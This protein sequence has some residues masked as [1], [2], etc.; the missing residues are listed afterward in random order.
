MSS[1][2]DACI[3]VAEEHG[4][5]VSGVYAYHYIFERGDKRIDTFEVVGGDGYAVNPAAA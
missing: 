5:T 3:C 2:D 4:D 1:R